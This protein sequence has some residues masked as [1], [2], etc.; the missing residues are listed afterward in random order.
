MKLLENAIPNAHNAPINPSPL[1]TIPIIPIVVGHTCRMLAVIS[2]PGTVGGA[3]G[4]DS[5]GGATGMLGA[6]GG[7]TTGGTIVG[8]FTPPA[9][10]VPC[11]VSSAI[12]RPSR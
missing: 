11:S 12:A 2:A 8:W 9:P 7:D 5:R 6:I 3:V 4:G 1:I 10:V